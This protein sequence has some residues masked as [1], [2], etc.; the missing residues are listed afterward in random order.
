V[1][2]AKYLSLF[3]MFVIALSVLSFTLA[4][5]RL[6]LHLIN[7]G[8]DVLGCS[9][10]WQGVVGHQRGSVSPAHALHGPKSSFQPTASSPNPRA[11]KLARRL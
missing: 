9:V 3:I 1:C 11:G 8:D 4:S 2:Q 5:V 10:V 6:V 7:A